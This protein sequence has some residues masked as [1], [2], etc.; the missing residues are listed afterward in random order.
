MVGVINRIIEDFKTDTPKEKEYI[1]FDV[2]YIYPKDISKIKDKDVLIIFFG[3]DSIT[4]NELYENI[5]K[6]ENNYDWTKKIEDHELRKK[7]H[8]NVIFSKML[9]KE[10]EKYKILYFDTSKNRK[11][12]LERVF[13]YIRKEVKKND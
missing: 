7:C 5:R 12:V 3:Y 10:C 11:E 6:Y 9:K 1:I 2:P 8:E 13:N 4:G